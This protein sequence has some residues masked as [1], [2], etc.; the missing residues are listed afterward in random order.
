M[1]TATA[2]TAGSVTEAHARHTLRIA[3]AGSVD[4]GKSTLIGRLLHDTK[5]VF[6]DQLRAV[7]KASSRY[8]D[9]ST[10]LAL[11]TDGLRAE[12][13]QGITIDVAHRYFATPRRSFIVADTPGHA[14]YTRN[15][16]TGASTSDVA[17]VLVDARHGVVDQTRR[18]ALIASLLGVQQIV[19]AVNKMD[20]VDWDEGAFLRIAKEVHEF[21]DALPHPAPVHAIP[22]SALLGDHV[23]DRSANMPWFDGAPLLEYLE[24]VDATDPHRPGVRLH[25]QRVIR[26]QGGEHA[27]FRG[28]AGVVHGGDLRTGDPIT[29]LPS[30]R[31]SS[32]AAIT[33]WGAPVTVAEPGHAV[34]VELTDDVDVARGDVLV[35]PSDTLPAVGHDLVVDLCWMVDQPL[36]EGTRWWFKHGTRTGHAIVTQVEH[37]FDLTTAAVAAANELA[38]ND[39]GRV[40]LAVTEPVVAD[41]YHVHAPDG[42]LILIDPATNTTAAAAMVHE[43]VS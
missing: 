41:R 17:I 39:I 11:L 27:D 22:M 37:R 29:V 10:N 14:Q 21:V 35:G 43:V 24:E 16:V 40:H 6:E 38:L 25:V 19:V 33:R 2:T 32:V 3:T 8:G 20:L 42:R 28:Y 23:V 15:M 7:V 4:D 5:T 31:G 13:E 26:P 1:T 18:H 12:R 34:V 9:G 36:A 30:G